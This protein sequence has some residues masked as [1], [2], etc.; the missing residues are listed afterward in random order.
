MNTNQDVKDFINNCQVVIIAGG[1]GQGLKHRTGDEI[2][3]PLLKI[4]DKALIDYCI[5]L[6]SRAGFKN[7]ILLLGHLAE[8]IQSYVGDGSKYGV[9]IKYSVEK[10]KLG[11]GGAIKLALENGTIDRNKPC[12]IAYPDDLITDPNFPQEIIKGHLKGLKLGALATIICVS[13]TF[14]RYGVPKLNERGFVIEFE[15][16]PPVHMPAT[17]GRYIL[18]HEVYK[19]VEEVIGKKKPA[20]F[21]KTVLPELAKRGV[22]FNHMI[23]VESW[24][25]VNDEKEFREAEEVMSKIKR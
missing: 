4:N 3:K 19:I 22:L 2:P 13:K 16:K 18:Q 23:P 14:Y 8:M 20:D 6:F 21:E 15:E 5:E 9:S 7:F 17:I 11:K 24:I 25:P 1:L 12:V 10:E